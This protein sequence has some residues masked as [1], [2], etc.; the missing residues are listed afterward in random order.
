MGLLLKFSGKPDLDLK[1]EGQVLHSKRD[2]LKS[3]K[4][5]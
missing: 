2:F 5:F 1:L 4:Q 3:L